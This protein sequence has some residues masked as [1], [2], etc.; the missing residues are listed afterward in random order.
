MEY[1]V[2]TIC[3]IFW[4]W[5]LVYACIIIPKNTK[6][7]NKFNIRPWHLP[8]MLLFMI[9]FF[10]FMYHHIELKNVGDSMG[11]LR[12]FFMNGIVTP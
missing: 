5:K 3:T 12:T 7:G 9:L 1:Q 6:C 2:L 11:F 8:F 4:G 10:G